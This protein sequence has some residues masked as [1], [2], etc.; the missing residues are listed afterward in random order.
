MK[1]LIKNGTLVLGDCV[2]K[3]DLL[4]ENGKIALVRPYI[5]F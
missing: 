4:I 3:A 1:L 2:K 5:E